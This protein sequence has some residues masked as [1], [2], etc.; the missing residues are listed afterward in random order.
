[1][2][3]LLQEIREKSGEL[4]AKL[5]NEIILNN[6]FSRIPLKS[7]SQCRWVCKT[8]YRLIHHPRFAETHY[9]SAIQNRCSPCLV[10]GCPYFGNRLRLIDHQVFDNL[11]TSVIGRDVECFRLRECLRNDSQIIGF[12]N[13]LLCLG[14][15]H[16]HR[17]PTTYVI[18]NPI[19]GEYIQIPNNSFILMTL[20]LLLLALLRLLMSI[21]LFVVATANTRPDEPTSIIAFNVASERF[22]RFESPPPVTLEYVFRKICLQVIEEQLYFIGE[23]TLDHFDFDMWV[24]KDYGVPGSWTK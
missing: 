14:D 15:D 4:F 22:H 8:W 7:L 24:M 21:R 9:Q 2:L 6:I 20:I 19:T 12:V 13:G 1:M 17:D 5:P 18:Y 10:L 3:E 16:I 23:K 11:E